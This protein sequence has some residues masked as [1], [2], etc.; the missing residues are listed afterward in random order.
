MLNLVSQA[1]RASASFLPQSFIS[2]PVAP[3]PHGQDVWW[4]Y[5]LTWPNWPM[6]IGIS[7]YNHAGTP[8]MLR[9]NRARGLSGENL[10]RRSDKRRP[11]SAPCI[12][13]CAGRCRWFRTISLP[14]VDEEGELTLFLFLILLQVPCEASIAMAV[15]Q[16]AS[17]QPMK[18]LYH[19]SPRYM[20]L[21]EP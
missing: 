21:M 2:T 10:R 19:F 4:V 7:I 12:R 15:G 16:L 9:R 5:H 8:P 1:K 13:L 18:S 11:R 6:H 20:V 3:T 17:S 14:D